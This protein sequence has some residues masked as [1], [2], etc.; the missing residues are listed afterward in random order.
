MNNPHKVYKIHGSPNSWFKMGLGSATAVCG[1]H[2]ES[3]VS[4]SAAVA[5]DAAAVAARQGAVGTAAATASSIPF[6][7]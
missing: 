3:V 5:E 4:A 6:H 1:L 7:T 2:D